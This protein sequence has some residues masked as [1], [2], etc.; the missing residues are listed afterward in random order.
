M[1]LGT[2]KDYAVQLIDEFS[3]K[4][5]KTDDDDIR[6]KLNNLFNMGQIELSNIRKIKRFLELEISDID[7][8]I[9]YT[10]P[11]NFKELIRVDGSPNNEIKYRIQEDGHEKKIKVISQLLEKIEIE[12]YST[13]SIID[14]NTSDSYKFEIDLDAQMLLPYYV[15]SDILK[16]DVSA[17]YTSFEAKYSN[18][19]ELLN[20]GKNSDVSIEIKPFSNL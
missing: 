3:N 6:V 7:K 10:L 11:E 20:V 9:T 13:P 4:E 15:A 18:K 12:Y 8:Y 14:D 16:S 17:D 2:L 1:N 19:L 5:Y